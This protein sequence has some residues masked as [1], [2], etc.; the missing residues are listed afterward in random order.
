MVAVISPAKEHS[1]GS[2]SIRRESTGTNGDHI[3]ESYNL[4]WLGGVLCC[5]VTKLAVCIVAP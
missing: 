5:G 1:V 2:Y 4:Q 3:G